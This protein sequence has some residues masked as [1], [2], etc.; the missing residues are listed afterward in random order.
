MLLL[1]ISLVVKRIIEEPAAGV[2]PT[3]RA[4]ARCALARVGTLPHHERSPQELRP[5]TPKRADE[6]AILDDDHVVDGEATPANGRVKAE[7][8]IDVDVG[9]V[10]VVVRKPVVGVAD[11]DGHRTTRV[12]VEDGDPSRGRE[13]RR[14]APE[15][16]LSDPPCTLI[17]VEKRVELIGSIPCGGRDDHA[18]LEGERHALVEHPPV[19]S[20]DVRTVGPAERAIGG[21]HHDEPSGEVLPPIAELHPGRE[22]EGQVRPRGHDPCVRSTPQEV[23]HLGHR[24]QHG[25]VIDPDGGVE[26]H[27]P[28]LPNGHPGQLRALGRREGGHEPAA[29]V[30]HVL[31]VDRTGH[32]A[33]PLLLLGQH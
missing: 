5:K 27:L 12:L 10:P 19:A 31:L 4:P 1:T 9:T 3:P 33:V 17:R 30:D 7:W 18:V 8:N 20:A 16:E 13:D 22:L 23:T 11:T 6:L 25:R 29:G 14:V 2:Q 26:D 28:V 21:L 24:R 32:P 15:L